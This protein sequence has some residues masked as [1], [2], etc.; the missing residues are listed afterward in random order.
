MRTYCLSCKKHTDNIGSKNVISANKI[1]REASKCSNCV[2]KKSVFLKQKFD[3]KIS[4]SKIN[5]NFQTQVIIK[6]VDILLE[7][8]K[9]YR[10]CRSKS[11]K[12]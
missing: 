2:A 8:Q 10:K 5:P 9:R 1:T 4:W 3:K 7:V 12:D 6:H 11:V